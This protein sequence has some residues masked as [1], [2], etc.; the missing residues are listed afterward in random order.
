MIHVEGI[1]LNEFAI[2]T[3]RDFL[4]TEFGDARRVQDT[5]VHQERAAQSPCHLKGGA[6]LG[7]AERAEEGS[8]LTFH[9][10]DG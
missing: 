4:R 8:L 6:L 7:E 9:F 2:S 5:Y 3:L 1:G 10:L